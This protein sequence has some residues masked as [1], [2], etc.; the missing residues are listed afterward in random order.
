MAEQNIAEPNINTNI[1]K[2]KENIS[3]PI[4]NLESD[5]VESDQTPNEGIDKINR[6]SY[7]SEITFA[8]V[9]IL[10]LIYGLVSNH[11]T[12]IVTKTSEDLG[13]QAFYFLLPIFLYGLGGLIALV[14]YLFTKK[15][16]QTFH[17]STRLLAVLL[18]LGATFGTINNARGELD[19]LSHL[20]PTTTKNKT[21]SLDQNFEN[22]YYS[23]KYPREWRMN[24]PSVSGFISMVSL[25]SSASINENYIQLD[26]AISK[27]TEG[28]NF[29]LTKFSENSLNN[30][31]QLFEAQKLKGTFSEITTIVVGSHKTNSFTV[32][33]RQNG[34]D[35][36]E[37]MYLI[38]NINSVA[39]VSFITTSEKWN[40]L[41]QDIVSSIVLK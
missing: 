16:K 33:F 20:A 15:W 17:F 31:K 7:Q 21:S 26:I 35:I 28:Q 34:Y 36:I 23:F 8:I 29:E 27:N 22:E 2:S 39:S 13:R 4:T 41:E 30:T 1:E 25:S 40:K 3:T 38:N 9:V 37:T 12:P 6:K 11:Y 5:V 18:C 14:S 24:Q 32:R 10:S 19:M